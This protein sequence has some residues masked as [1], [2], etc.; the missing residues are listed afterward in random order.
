ME[1]RQFKKEKKNCQILE[2]VFYAHETF[3]KNCMENNF[4]AF[5][6]HMT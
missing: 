2:K 4:I 5:R 3:C 1:R 6:G